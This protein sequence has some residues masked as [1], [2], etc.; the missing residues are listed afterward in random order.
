MDVFL[1]SRYS[2]DDGIVR[3]V[4][5]TITS[6]VE[7]RE[8]RMAS[9]LLEGGFFYEEVSPVSATVPTF[10]PSDVPFTPSEAACAFRLPWPPAKNLPGFSVKNSRTSF[11]DLPD[12]ILNSPDAV[13]IGTKMH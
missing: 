6:G 11:A 2:I 9:E 3:T 1:F 8:L 5:Q 13:S 7:D 4:G 10:I 12:D